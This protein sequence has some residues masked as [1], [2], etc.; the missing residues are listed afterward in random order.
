M[1][2]SQRLDGLNLL[3]LN[4]MPVPNWSEVHN[5]AAV[6]Q[7]KLPRV[8]FG[9]TIRTC[10]MDGKRETGLFYGNYLKADEVR[11]ILRKR[12]SDTRQVEFYLVYPSW[13]FRFSCNIVLADNSYIIEGKYGSQKSLSMGKTSPDFGLRIPFGIRSEMVS[14]AGN[15]NNEVSSWLGRI[16]WWCKK[17]PLKSF[18][19]EICLMQDSNLM[20]YE[21]FDLSLGHNLPFQE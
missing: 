14:Y 7:L 13:K 11:A 5:S 17:I 19:S 3:R 21:L 8:A 9:W 4:G 16:L 15:P 20:F 2:R 18:Y 6:V 1:F 12:F 10:R